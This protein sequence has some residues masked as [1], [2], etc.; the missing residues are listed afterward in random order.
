MAR[1]WGCGVGDV[2]MD[3]DKRPGARSL[4]EGSWVRATVVGEGE[5]RLGRAR[6]RRR[7]LCEQRDAPS[8]CVCSVHRD[9]ALAAAMDAIES[10]CQR[11]R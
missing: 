2:G 4:G 10:I 6:A 3:M 8:C 5:S 7:L 9:D 11:K 1:V